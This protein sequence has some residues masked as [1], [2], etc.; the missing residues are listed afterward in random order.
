[1]DTGLCARVLLLLEPARL[2]CN[3]MLP[4]EAHPAASQGAMAAAA[5]SSADSKV[6]CV[7]GASGY[8]ASQL[9]AA[10]LAKGCTVSCHVVL[11]R[12]SVCSC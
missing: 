11:L 9:V 8:V 4:A 12:R 10:L 6:V 2:L 7:T 1:M 5:G 3:W